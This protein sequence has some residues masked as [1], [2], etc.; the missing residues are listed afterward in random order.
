MQVYICLYYFLQWLFDA[1]IN[2]GALTTIYTGSQISGFE[3]I[4]MWKIFYTDIASWTISFTSIFKGWYMG[5][6]QRRE[7]IVSHY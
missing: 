3:A 2:I 7:I 5:L 1:A 6:K 4:C